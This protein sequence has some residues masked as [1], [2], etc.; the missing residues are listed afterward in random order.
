[1]YSRLRNANLILI[2]KWILDLGQWLSIRTYH[3]V[4]LE[5]WE[6]HGRSRCISH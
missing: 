5:Q 4:L 6:H 3:R 2:G 1:M